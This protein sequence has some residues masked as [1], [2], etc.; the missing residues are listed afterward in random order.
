[1]KKKGRKGEGRNGESEKG[2]RDEETKGLIYFPSNEKR[3]TSNEQL[4]ENE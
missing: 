1:M 4:E 3:G 2:I